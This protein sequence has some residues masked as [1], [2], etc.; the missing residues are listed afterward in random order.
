MSPV[1]NPHPKA[2]CDIGEVVVDIGSGLGADCLLAGQ[3]VGLPRAKVIG[4][5][6][7]SR[8]VEAATER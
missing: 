8:E 6:L 5:D 1:G 7:S 2:A 4:I 3:A